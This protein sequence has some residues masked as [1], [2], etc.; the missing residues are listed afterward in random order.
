MNAQDRRAALLQ[1]WEPIW[2]ARRIGDSSRDYRYDRDLR[3]GRV[4]LRRPFIFAAIVHVLAA[5]P[6]VVV[7]HPRST[8]PRAAHATSIQLLSLAAP[9]RAR[10]TR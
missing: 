9:P 1:K 3:P 10:M 4:T 7:L 8:P 2:D 6:F 5:L